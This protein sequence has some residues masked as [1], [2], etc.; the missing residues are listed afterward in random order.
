MIRAEY[1]VSSINIVIRTEPR[2][3]YFTSSP[4]SSTDTNATRKFMTG[5]ARETR[6]IPFFRSL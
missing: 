1:S 4:S 2:E 6:M 5:P 3:P